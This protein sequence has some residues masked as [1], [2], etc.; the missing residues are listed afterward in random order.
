MLK[1]ILLVCFLVAL[2]VFANAQDN[3]AISENSAATPHASAALDVQSI[4]KGFLA[5]RVTTSQRETIQNPAEYLIVLN[6]ESNCLEV[7]FE[8]K[9][10]RLSCPQ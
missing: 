9:W 3:V 4:T 6:T 5:P 2:Y 7:Y 10:W 8:N 1:K